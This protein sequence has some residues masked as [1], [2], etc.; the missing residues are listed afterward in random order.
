MPVR[1]RRLNGETIMK[2]RMQTITNTVNCV[3][4]MGKGVALKFKQAH[5]ANFEDYEMRCRRN[6][7]RPGV[8]YVFP[9]D[10][11]RDKPDLELVLNFPTKDHWRSPS[12]IEWVDSGLKILAERYGE[13]G[14]T[15]LAL[16]ALG[17]GNGGL[18]WSEV[19]PLIQDHLGSLPI[20]IEVWVPDGEEADD[21]AGPAD[22]QLD[23]FSD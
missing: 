11:K 8:P 16:P 15:S 3:G 22:A 6:Q 18:Q 7:V 4:V 10:P 23:L 19:W 20:E 9:A 17:C 21:E 5:R 13:W 1:R 14:V 2:S 12:R